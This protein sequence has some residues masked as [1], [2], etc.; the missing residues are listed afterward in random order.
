MWTNKSSWISMNSQVIVKIVKIVK[1]H[2]AKRALTFVSKRM[3]MCMK[4]LLPEIHLASPLGNLDDNSTSTR[5]SFL[6]VAISLSQIS[7]TRECT[8]GLTLQV[9]LKVDPQ[10]LQHASAERSIF[11]SPSHF[12]PVPSDSWRLKGAA[13]HPDSKLKQSRTSQSLQW[14]ANST[15]KLLRGR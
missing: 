15:G 1:W 12:S 13:D 10:V 2:L 11:G 5:I 9:V 7:R 8:T 6:I 3:N 4:Q 14:E